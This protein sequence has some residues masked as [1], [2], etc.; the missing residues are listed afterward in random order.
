MAWVLYFVFVLSG[1]AGLVYETV[2][3]RY[4]GLFV[5]HSAYAQIIVLVIFL[6]GMSLGAWVVSGRSADI[7]RPLRWY[8]GVELLVGVIGL[9][10]HDVFVATTALAYDSI[11]PALGAGVALT[12]VKWLLAALLIVPQSILLGMTFPLMSAGVLRTLRTPADQSGRVLAMLYFTNSLGAAAGGLAA[13]FWLVE[14]A[15][16]P[17]TLY[18][19]AGMNITV[20]LCVVVVEQLT[21]LKAGDVPDARQGL[22]TRPIEAT[23]AS[24]RLER[25]L[26]A[27]AGATA[28]AS[29]IYEI[30]WIRM[31]SLVLGA[32]THSFELMLSAFITG[33]AAGALWA[34]KRAD[35][36]ADP[37]RALAQ[38]QLVMGLLAVA[39]LP[40][41]VASFHWQAQLLSGLGDTESA[42]RMF[43]VAKYGISLAVMLPATFCAGV[44][45]PLI[46]RILLANGAG[47]RAIGRVYAVNTLGSIIGAS[48]AALLLMP[49][50]GVKGL[51]V[52]GAA[53]DIAAGLWLLAGAA[54]AWRAPR[55]WAGWAALVTAAVVS[56]VVAAPFDRLL[57]SS[58]VYRYASAEIAPSWRSIFYA[59]GRTA[60]VSAR[61]DTVTGERSL[62]T[63]G[64]PDASLPRH[65]MAP[66]AAD[67][68]PPTV[69]I[70]GDQA[71]QF[72]LPLITLAHNPKARHIA[73]VGQGSGM[74]S[75]VL[76]GIDGVTD[77]TTIEIEP[78][79]IEGSK[80]FLPANRRVFE[81]PRSHFRIDDAR[82]VFAAGH[83]KYD[84]IMSEPSNPWVSGVSGLFTD[85]FYQ[86]ARASLAEGGVFGQWLQLYESNDALVLTVL[87]AVHRNFASY[88]LHL[89]SGTDLLIVAS[90]DPVLAVPDWSVVNAPRI[91]D[92][93]KRVV[94]LTPAALAATW[95]ADREALTPLLESWRA[96]NSDFYP[97]LDLATERTRFVRTAAGGVIGLSTDRFAMV[98]AMRFRRI[99]P[100]QELFASM[101]L[102][103]ITQLAQGAR[104]REALAGRLTPQ[105]INADR[106]VA[107]AVFGY[108][109]LMALATSGAPPGDWRAWI[110]RVAE[111]DDALEGGTAGVA[112]TAFLELLQQYAARTGAPPGARAAIAF[113]KA[114]SLWDWPRAAA[115]SDTLLRL[116]RRGEPWM[117]AEMLR[118]GGVVARLR[119]GDTGGARHLFNVLSVVVNNNDLRTMLLDSWIKQAENARARAAMQQE[120]D[121]PPP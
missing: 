79:M 67:A 92:D 35:R 27:V 74:S 48:A 25:A 76:L 88:S 97:Y 98:N 109:S 63:N 54:D 75:H 41:Y 6:G 14:L 49:I 95:I 62:A 58:G 30:A 108:R 61:L 103:R 39:T 119:V 21:R 36:F 68:P 70:A 104:L 57:L 80:V 44:T 93:L 4:L 72:L 37:V 112:D 26:L 69:G 117:G 16:L 66:L 13:G 65:W 86:R 87:A 52:V 81:D 46:T 91:A 120:A 10:F 102:G 47:E 115:L 56:I 28:V 33:L 23:T 73:A 8:V 89:V 82:S 60:T 110:A 96:V 3:S 55:A 77:V 45:L 78:A 15:G 31:L 7:A 99:L 106:G 40:V 18:A 111:V 1:A 38:V 50:L 100:G 20:A 59:D 22:G 17:G 114:T 42:Y 32:A 105:A 5:G 11:F 107:T 64:K 24:T 71:A 85:E 19:A 2:W 84:L 51:L 12:I 29:F 94:R 113:I 34:R 101:Q 83:V 118:A 9:L 121:K 43:S 53:V 116:E 90:P